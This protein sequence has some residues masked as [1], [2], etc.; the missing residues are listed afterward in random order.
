MSTKIEAR[1]LFD[2]NGVRPNIRVVQYDGP[3]IDDKA[4]PFYMIVADY[5]WA[6]RIVCTGMYQQ[7][8][9]AIEAAINEAIT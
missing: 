6:E 3:G 5:G 4:T 7:D 9:L 2:W 1:D 8:A